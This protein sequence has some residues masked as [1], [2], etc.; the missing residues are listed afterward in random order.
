MFLF[1]IF[2][3]WAEQIKRINVFHAVLSDYDMHMQL[4]VCSNFFFFSFGQKE[5][6]KKNIKNK[7]IKKAKKPKK[8]KLKEEILLTLTVQCSK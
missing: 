2:Y 6:H 3:Y 4:Y 1:F 5:L 7:E 8:M